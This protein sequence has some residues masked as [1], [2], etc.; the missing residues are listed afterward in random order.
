MAVWFRRQSLF[1][2]MIDYLQPDFYRFNQDSLI[3]S[4]WV[5]EHFSEAKNVLDI[6]TGC[7]VIGLE[8]A[9]KLELKKLCLLE[10]QSDYRPFLEKNVAQFAPKGLE[11]ELVFSAFSEW[12]TKRKFDLIVCNPPY[13]LPHAGRPSLDQ[14]R[15]LAR[16]FL[17]DGWPSL[18]RFIQD[19]LSPEG[20]AFLVIKNERELLKQI[21]GTNFL[22]HDLGDVLIL[23]LA[24]P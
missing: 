19:R 17:K 15:G 5:I 20:R 12:I 7:G 18:I 22:K 24:N 13:Y 21:E 2:K 1:L 3:L 4:K 23:E 10:L 9:Q 11:V 16:S 6:G 14:R 8:I